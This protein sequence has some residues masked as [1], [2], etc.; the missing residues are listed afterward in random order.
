MCK[1][2]NDEVVFPAHKLTTVKMFRLRIA[3]EYLNQCL[4]F[5]S[6]YRLQSL[7]IELYA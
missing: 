7:G 5:T 3:N 6:S 2:P 4:Q 1:S